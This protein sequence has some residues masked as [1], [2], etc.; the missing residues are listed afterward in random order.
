MVCERTW[1]RTK[2]LCFLGL[3]FNFQYCMHGFVEVPGWLH[4]FICFLGCVN[5]QCS[6]HGFVNLSGRI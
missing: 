1:M 5:F 2:F 4:S 3:A 6:M